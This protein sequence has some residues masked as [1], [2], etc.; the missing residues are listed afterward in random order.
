V[1]SIYNLYARQNAY[2][3]F[4]KTKNDNYALYL[5]KANAYK[6]SIF[7]TIFPS[8]TYNFKF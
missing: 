5:K 7:G 1:F 2:S 4:F 8:I 3:I 6:L